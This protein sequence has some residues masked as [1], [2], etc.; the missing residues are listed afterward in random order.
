MY[1]GD[2]NSSIPSGFVQSLLKALVG[3][4]IVLVTFALIFLSNEIISPNSPSVFLQVAVAG[5]IIMAMSFLSIK[6]FRGLEYV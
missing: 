2:R 5:V 6:I 4:G 3:L 1:L